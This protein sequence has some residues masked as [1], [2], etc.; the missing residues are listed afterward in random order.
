[1]NKYKLILLACLAHLLAGCGAQ[2]A[3]PQRVPPA[4]EVN[5]KRD[6]ELHTLAVKDMDSTYRFMLIGDNLYIS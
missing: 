3:E 4:A 1:M 5:L 2:E 6:G